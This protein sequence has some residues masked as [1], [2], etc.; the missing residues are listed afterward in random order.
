MVQ[1]SHQM[2]PNPGQEIKVSGLAPVCGK[3]RKHA[4]DPEVP[5]CS[6]QGA[7]PL[8]LV[9]TLPSEIREMRHHI[10]G[11]TRG[12]I[13]P[14]VGQERDEIIG[15]MAN[16]GV[17]EVDQPNSRDTRTILKPKEVFGCLLY[18]SPSPRDS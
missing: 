16:Q 12:E 4:Q 2:P 1:R 15:R 7:G 10:L 3:P 18:T 13:A 6:E 11:K 9:H 5:L 8:Q 14:G 17:L